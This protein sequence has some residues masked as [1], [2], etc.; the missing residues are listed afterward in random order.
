MRNNTFSIF[1]LNLFNLVFCKTLLPFFLGPLVLGQETELI[2]S[3]SVNN[4]GYVGLGTDAPKTKFNA[5]GKATNPVNNVCPTGYDWYDENRNGVIDNGE[6]KITVLV[7]TPSGSVGIGTTNPGAELVVVDSDGEAKIVS[8]GYFPP[9]YT[10]LKG[11]FFQ[12][13]TARG[14]P[15]SPS[16]VQS[17]DGIALFGG[18]GYEGSGFSVTTAGMVVHAAED[19][20]TT[21]QGSYINFNTTPNGNDSHDWQVRM[22]INENGTIGIGTTT[23]SNKLSVNGSLGL[24]YNNSLFLYSNSGATV[25]GILGPGENGD[26][27]LSSEKNN[28]WLRIGASGSTNSDAAVA[29]WANGQARQ[30]NSPQM[31]LNSTGRLGIGTKKPALNLNVDPQGEGGILIGNPNWG[32]GGYTSLA[33]VIS[34]AKGGYTKIQAIK[35]SG[36]SYGTIALNAEGGNVGIGTTT[37]TNGRLQIENSPT[38]SLSN[39]AAYAKSGTKS[40][41]EVGVGTS[42]G[43][44]ALYTPDRLVA[45]EFDATCDARIKNIRGVSDR[46][47]DLKTLMA[48]EITD[49]TYRDSVAKGTIPQKKVIGQQ[50]ARVYPQAVTLNTEVVPDIMRPARLQGGKIHLPGHGLNDGARV[51]FLFEN[52]QREVLPVTVHSKDQFQIS[53]DREGKT[54][55]YGRE[56]ED[57]H[58]VD[59]QA[60]ATLHMSAT[61]ELVRR[62]GVLEDENRRLRAEAKQRLGQ[63]EKTTATVQAQNGQLLRRL[64]L[65]EAA[66]TIPASGGSVQ[67]TGAL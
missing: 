48:V 4:Q 67:Q 60:L 19:W 13:V 22:R 14:T 41:H 28:H 3:I 34:A 16:P 32:S 27:T 37:P 6:C 39:Y 17:G 12:G 62:V 52:G 61:Q 15:S 8:Q 50:I 66:M 51:E 24:Y 45:S 25:G 57:F 55:V 63:M 49:Y 18:R 10:A 58:V 56:V 59:I 7:G 38:I 30:D 31:F 53:T 42:S 26:L 21:A 20:T 40:P 5:T 23:T 47:A 9:D 35:S 64:K 36:T 54:F 44:V 11:G 29:F 1:K 2:P 33:M 43:P 46:A 65:L